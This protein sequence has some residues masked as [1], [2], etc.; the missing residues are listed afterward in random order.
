MSQNKKYCDTP[1]DETSLDLN[2]LSKCTIAKDKDDTQKVTLNV[3]A[4]R[5]RKRIIR[6]REKVNTIDGATKDLNADVTPSTIE[7]KNDIV[8]NRMEAETVLFNVVDIVPLFPACENAN[9][10][11]TDCFNN[12]FSK[13]FAKTFD[14]ERASEEGVSGRVF[15]QFTIDSKGK[16]ENLLVKGRKKEASLE[17]E[18]KRVVS[19]LPVFSPARH[20]G[21]PVKVKYSLPISFN[22]EY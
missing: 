12:E 8:T 19:K 18:I 1:S 7:I 13:H 5:T 10:N 11:G 4:K 17:N 9:K 3:A 15:I 6:K 16:V 22:V 14:P 2:T 20:K 21:L